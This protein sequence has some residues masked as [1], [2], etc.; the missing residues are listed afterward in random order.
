M[1]IKHLKYFVLSLALLGLGQVA[2]AQ[3][4]KGA[5]TPVTTSNT[6]SNTPVTA[7]VAS[8]SQPE[9]SDKTPVIASTPPPSQQLPQSEKERPRTIEPSSLFL[10]QVILFLEIKGQ[11][12]AA[13]PTGYH[14]DLNQNLFILNDT[15][16]SAPAPTS[17][18]KK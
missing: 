4:P 9:S 11:L 1:K 14:F 5:N 2:L 10:K 7:P 17:K 16:A 8:V 13:T 12:E 18:V 3:V 15:S 6:P